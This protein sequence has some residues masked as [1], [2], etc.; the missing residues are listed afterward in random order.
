MSA[1]V[2]AII[3]WLEAVA[4][5]VV[6]DAEDQVE[7]AQRLD[8]ADDL[9][10][11]LFVF[12]AVDLVR[13]IAENVGDATG[14]SVLAAVDLDAG[15]TRDFVLVLSAV[16]LALAVGRVDWPSRPAARSA[17]ATLQLRAE[18][19]YA[20]A[21]PLSADL[22]SWLRALVQVAVRLVSEIAANSAPLVQ[23]STP[24]S[25]ASTVAAYHLYGDANRAGD[26]VDIARSG[27]PMLMP[28]SF[29]AL[30]R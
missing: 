18:Q 8:V 6:V 5:A 22:Y 20:V 23:V 4:G 15:G 7:L 28:S 11:E 12:E 21:A 27:T 29:E 13:I 14:F 26:V 19:A 9:P 17:R 24:I 10:V 25:I 1:D 2:S 3:A 30:A 16:A